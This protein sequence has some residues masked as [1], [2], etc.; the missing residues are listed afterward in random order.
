[1]PSEHN[2]MVYTIWIQQLEF[3]QGCQVQCTTRI[4]GRECRWRRQRWTKHSLYTV[5]PKLH[6]FLSLGC[7]CQ[8]YVP[9]DLLP[10]DGGLGLK[11]AQSTSGCKMV[12]KDYWPCLSLQPCRSRRCFHLICF[13]KQY[14]SRFY[15]IWQGGKYPNVFG[16]RLHSDFSLECLLEY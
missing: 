12:R 4:S 14:L 10:V 16:P 5:R 3:E 15:L 8:W 7:P 9:S 13:D 11:A 1:M 2:E 6:E